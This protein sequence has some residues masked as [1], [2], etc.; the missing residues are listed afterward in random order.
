MSVSGGPYI[1]LATN[2]IKLNI[3][4]IPYTPGMVS[5]KV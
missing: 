4:I 2:K 3:K 5:Q 1:F